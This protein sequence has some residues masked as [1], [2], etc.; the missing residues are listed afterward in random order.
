M[1]HIL[2]GMEQYGMR[3]HHVI[4][5][6][7]QFPTWDLLISGI[8]YLKFLDCGQ[9]SVT[10]TTEGKNVNKGDYC[11]KRFLLSGSSYTGIQVILSSCC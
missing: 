8:F 2:G 7:V 3:F 6:N 10:E 9:P 11:I 4:Q 1:F 5:N